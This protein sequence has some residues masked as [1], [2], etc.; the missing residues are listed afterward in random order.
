MFSI[1]GRTELGDCR[2]IEAWNLSLRKRRDVRA[3][4]TFIHLAQELRSKIPGAGSSSVAL[5]SS[6]LKY[7]RRISISASEAYVMA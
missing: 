3:V 4:V 1:L 6:S 2:G 7:F 5:K